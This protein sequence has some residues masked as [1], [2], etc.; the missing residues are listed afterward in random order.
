MCAETISANVLKV[1]TLYTGTFILHL[2]CCNLQLLS[3]C[4]LH[5]ECAF[6]VS[7]NQNSKFF[8]I[9]V[10]AL[11]NN[12]HHSTCSHLIRI[13]VH[14]RYSHNVLNL[15][16]GYLLLDTHTIHMPY[17]VCFTGFLVNVPHTFTTEFFLKEPPLRL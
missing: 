8:L 3:F 9:I 4:T 15:V 11:Y 7:T 10:A 5:P 13:D 1:T 6:N 16:I 17:T 14:C 2:S 12:F